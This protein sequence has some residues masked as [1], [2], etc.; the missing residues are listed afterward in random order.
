MLCGGEGDIP[1]PLKTGN[2]FEGVEKVYAGLPPTGRTFSVVPH[3]L[4]E[5]EKV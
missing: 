3:D 1:P 4:I 5:A 2:G